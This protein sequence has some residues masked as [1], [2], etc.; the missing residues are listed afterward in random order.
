MRSIKFAV[1]GLFL[2]ALAA[3]S[4]ISREPV[5]FASAS[6]PSPSFTNAPA[7]GNCTSCHIGAPLNGGGGSIQI[8][9][10]PAAY[11]L[12]QQIPVTV[13]ASQ[14]D[15]VVYGFQLTA[16][17]S[18]GKTVGSFALPNESPPRSQ[19]ISNVVEGNVRQYVEHT[20]DGLL[21]QSFG[22]N[23]WTF[24]WTAPSGPTGQVVFYAAG[25]A[26]NG[27]GS[28]S[29][30]FIYTKSVSVMEGPSAVSISGRVL[31]ADGR[32]LRNALVRLSGPQSSVSLTGNLGYYS[33]T[34]LSPGQ[35]YTLSV[36]AKRYRFESRTV[37]PS[38]NL[39]DFDLTGLE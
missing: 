28:P 29:G 4:I 16:I 39:T 13:T 3:F 21:S 14:D 7:E 34:D 31:T 15:A 6:G 8:T 36:G 2:T 19:I 35:S 10:L 38:E 9:G 33:F 37:T 32:G 27:D 11:S 23:S 17:D 24:I 25:N 18:T 22:T 30:D 20:I 1:I 26:A 12:G 5:A